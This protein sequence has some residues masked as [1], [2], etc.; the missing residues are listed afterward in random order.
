MED[1]DLNGIEIPVTRV[2]AAGEALSFDIP[3]V[4]L[5]LHNHYG[6]EPPGPAGH[7]AATVVCRVAHGSTPIDA[8]ARGR[9][10]I[11][12]LLT[13]QQLESSR[14]VAIQSP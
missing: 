6:D 3:L 10:S 13:W 7:G 14:P 11:H 5:R 8:A 2:L 4:P 1:R 12:T 9:T